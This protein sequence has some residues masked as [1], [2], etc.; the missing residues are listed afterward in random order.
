MRKKVK[1]VLFDFDGT[2]V[3]SLPGWLHILSDEIKKLQK[4]SS[5]SRPLPNDDKAIM[6]EI[7]VELMNVVNYGVTVEHAFEFHKR[8]L[9]KSK[10][11]LTT[12]PLNEGVLEILSYL[13]RDHVALAIVSNTSTDTVSSSLKRHGI[14]SFFSSI[15]GRDRVKKTKPDPEAINLALSEIMLFPKEVIMIGDHMSDL[16]AAQKAG[17]RGILYAPFAHSKIYEFSKMKKKVQNISLFEEIT[18]YT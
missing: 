11:Y 9:R 12:A 6:E 14:Q 16:T 18:K 8:V 3:N 13:R 17:V 5:L 2:I 15:V 10:T 7:G 1:G 4:I